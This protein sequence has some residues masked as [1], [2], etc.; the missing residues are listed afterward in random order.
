MELGKQLLLCANIIMQI[1]EIELAVYFLFLSGQYLVT[2]SLL[3]VDKDQLRA[4]TAALKQH[5]AWK[6]LNFWGF[7]VIKQLSAAMQMLWIQ[8]RWHSLEVRSRRTAEEDA[9]NSQLNTIKLDPMMSTWCGAA[10]CQTARRVGFPESF[11]LPSQRGRKLT[12]LSGQNLHLFSSLRV[13][14]NVICWTGL[15]SYKFHWDW[16]AQ[17]FWGL[18]RWLLLFTFYAYFTWNISFCISESSHLCTGETSAEHVSRLGFYLPIW[19]GSHL[20]SP[21]VCVQKW[22]QR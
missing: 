14:A 9:S 12:T 13:F 15:K 1:R 19:G 10:L 22:K 5:S 8:N 20:C 21:W 4:Q 11:F 3:A 2:A 7:V 18:G 17:M 6:A 16:K